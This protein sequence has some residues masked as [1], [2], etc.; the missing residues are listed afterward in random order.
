MSCN[1]AVRPTCPPQ[2]SFSAEN[3][4]ALLHSAHP[5][6]QPP[7]PKTPIV[8][9]SIRHKTMSVDL[10]PHLIHDSHCGEQAVNPEGQDGENDGSIIDEACDAIH[11]AVKGWG[12]DEAGLIEVLGSKSA[13]DRTRIYRRYE[14]LY[15][16]DLERVLKSEQGGNFGTALR[17]LSLPPNEM[18]AT[19]LMKSMK[20]IGTREGHL[21]PILCGRS[22]SD[23]KAL[24]DAYLKRFNRD[25]GE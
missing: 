11:K 7:P 21:Y 12:T 3:F 8:T 23:I 16:K 19:L 4:A 17:L 22:N 18:E 5:G 24:K 25:L 15:E 14:T 13:E 6:A 10:Y 2:N 9:I 20:G 1:E